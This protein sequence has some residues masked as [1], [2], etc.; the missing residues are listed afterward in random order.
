MAP[1]LAAI[2]GLEP[3]LPPPKPPPNPPRPPAPPG[4]PALR[5]SDTSTYMGLPSTLEP[6]LDKA[7]STPCLFVNST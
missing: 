7:F 2:S 6:A 3:P 4:P 5:G 1:F